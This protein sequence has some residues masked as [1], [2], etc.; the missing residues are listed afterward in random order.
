MKFGDGSSSTEVS[1]ICTTI[2]THDFIRGILVL[3]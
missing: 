2:G 1:D 3:N